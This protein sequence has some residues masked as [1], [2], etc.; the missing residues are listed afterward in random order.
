M[1]S[2]GPKPIEIPNVVG[3]KIKTV[4]ANLDDLGLKIDRSNVFSETVEKNTVMSINPQA[5][6]TVPSGSTVELVVSKGPPPVTV[7]NLVDMPRKKALKALE[8]IGLRAKVEVGVVAPLNRV[9][10]QSPA[11]GTEIPKG[12]TVTIR[13][14]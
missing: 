13:I 10:S 8:K 7:P 5:G 1:I 3:Q 9:I 12:S 11:P 14:I 6:N 4:E 2:K